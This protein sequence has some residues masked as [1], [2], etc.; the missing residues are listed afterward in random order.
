MSIFDV[1]EPTALDFLMDGQTIGRDIALLE[2]YTKTIQGVG[3]ESLDEL[4][5]F[6]LVRQ[7]LVDRY[8]ERLVVGAG[9][10]GLFGAIKLLKLG[11]K[12]FRALMVANDNR[13][14]AKAA[15]AS[16]QFSIDL[17]AT[18]SGGREAVLG[19]VSAKGLS[20][21][22]AATDFGAAKGELKKL[23]TDMVSEIKTLSTEMEAAWGT[24]KPLY[25]KWSSSNEQARK[26]IVDRLKKSYP[27]APYAGFCDAVSL[28]EEKGSGAAV[29]ALTEADYGAAI[30]LLKEMIAG[31]DEIDALG[32]KV[33]KNVGDWKVPDSVKGTVFYPY[34]NG[35]SVVE[36]FVA[37]AFKARNQ[38]M[39]VAK[40]LE[41]WINNSFK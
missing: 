27:T 22:I 41:D 33:C 39:D 26:P 40:G 34:V 35:E 9:N 23:T 12:A 30:A 19:N 3:N 20:K 2:G 5:S 37:T 8:G 4:P 38:L 16:K 36:K 32:L 15:V 24:I 7:G 13:L 10:E 29:K 14:R 28:P 21:Q 25:S 18:D 17:K 6:Q 11:Y 1:R 31:I